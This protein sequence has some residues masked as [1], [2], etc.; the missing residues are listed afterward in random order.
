MFFRDVNDGKISDKQ[1]ASVEQDIMLAQ[2][3]GRIR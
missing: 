1:A 2:Q 3:E